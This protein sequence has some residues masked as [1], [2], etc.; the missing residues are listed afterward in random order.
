MHEAKVIRG[1]ALHNRSVWFIWPILPA[2]EAGLSR[3]INRGSEPCSVAQMTVPTC[4]GGTK[5]LMMRKSFFNPWPT[6][7][8][9]RSTRYLPPSRMHD[10]EAAARSVFP[11]SPEEEGWRACGRRM[12][13][14]RRECEGVWCVPQLEVGGPCRDQVVAGG[15]RVQVQRRQA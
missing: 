13:R 10:S 12:V 15:G 7:M 11:V 4:D 3:P 2:S 8:H 14:V 6:R 9:P 5:T 1:G